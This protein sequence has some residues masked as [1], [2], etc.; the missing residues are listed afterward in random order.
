MNHFEASESPRMRIAIVGTGIAGMSA[1]WLLNKAHDVTVYERSDYIGGH[2]NTVDAPLRDGGAVPVDTGFIVYNERNYPNLTALF[3]HLGVPTKASDMSFAAALDGGGLEYSGTDLNGLLGQRRNIVRP[4]FWRMVGDLLRFYREAPGALDD[5][6]AGAL[7]LGD[8]LQRNRYAACFVDDHLLPMGAAIW[9]TTAAEMKAYP[10]A[11]FIRFFQ[12]HGLLSLADRPQWRTVDGGSRAYV[13]QLTASYRNRIRFG[14][15]R[16]IR[17]TANGVLVEDRDGQVARYDHVVVATH[18]DEALA[19]LGDADA[20][21]TARL[22][23]WR[24][25]RNRAVLHRDPALMPRRR[26]VWSSWNFIGAPGGDSGR[27]LCVTYWMN[28]LQSLDTREPLFVTLNP[29]R[30][31]SPGTVIREFDYAHPLFDAA[32]LS[33]QQRLWSLQGHRRTWYCGS[34]FGCGFH[35]DALQSSL[36]VAERLGGLRRPWAVADENARIP[37]LDDREAVAA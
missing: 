6:M 4:R 33:G 12:S 20:L 31:P 2:S 34:Y 8:Y 11:A 32:A 21:E 14:G 28:R 18:A 7:S 22:G 24:Y 5:P 37:G 27:Q 35:E 17:R 26:R 23:D 3:R 25:T 16:A 1:A 13:E 10:A 9:S 29:V 36:A 19:L 15:V 30:E